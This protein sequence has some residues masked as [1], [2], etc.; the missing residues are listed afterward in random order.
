MPDAAA[1]DG[2]ILADASALDAGQPAPD[3]S[4]AGAILC[5]DFE[6]A[7]VGSP[8]AGWLTTMNGGTVAV[9]ATRARS[10]AHSVMFSAAAATGFRSVLMGWQR[11]L[12]TPANVVF[13]R[14]MFWLDSAPT[15]TVHWTF[16]DGTGLV[17]DGGY[18]AVYRYGGQ[19]PL[20]A[21][22][23]GFLGNQMMANYDTPDS[24]KSSPVGPA[25]DCYQHAQGRVVPVQTWTC[26]E[27]EFD[28][29]ADTMHMWIDGVEAP[30]LT[31]LQT[32]TGCT[33]QPSGFEW[34]A[35]RFQ[36]ID[37]GWESYQADD[38]RTIWIDDV[39]LA[40]S[41]IGCPSLAD[42]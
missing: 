9:D 17:P 12:P 3:G 2:A 14:M 21:A 22:D 33:Q 24:Y 20:T 38:A 41:R 27:W 37:L 11:S 36:R 40:T 1:A 19:L 28:G 13:G 39:A 4:C 30:D 29:A 6:E 8:P 18:H 25:S 34:T 32:G 10:G 42:E 15:N 31:V 26:L 23:G 5:E 7:G 35:P 16:V